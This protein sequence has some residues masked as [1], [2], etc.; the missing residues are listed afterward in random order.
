MEL[1]KLKEP[2]PYD[3]V[4]W[5][6]GA[7]NREKTK[8]LALA[9]I[10]ARA[11]MDRLDDVCGPSNWKDRY[12]TGPSGG[13]MCELSIRCGDEWI[14]KEDGA[15]N[16]D[17]EAVKGGISDA[18]RRAGVKW[19]IGRYLYHLDNQW[20]ECEAYGNSIRLKGR[21]TLPHW[22][23]PTGSTPIQR[24]PAPHVDRETGEV[25]APRP[26]PSA[27][28]KSAPKREWT[29]PQLK[30]LL[31]GNDLVMLD[32][33]PVLEMTVTRENFGF[34]IDAYLL[35]H[36]GENVATIIGKAARI[37]HGQKVEATA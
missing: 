13:V 11:V 4:K 21:P 24:E 25:T 36:P 23:L 32:L 8:A 31:E 30:A 12:R 28:A 15:E 7:T 2:F 10:D 19:G 6:P 5:R 17:I 18:L 37:K 16:T 33:T 20:V 3:D 14:A 34:A 1:A 26:A 29:G 35:G 22:A 9:F 27:A